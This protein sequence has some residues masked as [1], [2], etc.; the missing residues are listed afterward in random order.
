MDETKEVQFSPELDLSDTA[1]GALPEAHT[2]RFKFHLDDVLAFVFPTSMQHPLVCF[3][4]FAT[5][6]Q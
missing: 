6:A 1:L 2:D 5:E 3:R 4:L